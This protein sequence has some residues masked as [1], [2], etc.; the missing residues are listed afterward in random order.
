MSTSRRRFVQGA[1][2]LGLGL[3]TGCGRW[4]WQAQPP[5]RVPRI[6][7]LGLTAGATTGTTGFQQGLLELGWVDGQNLTIEWRWAEGRPERL[8][9]LAAELVHLNVDII[10]AVAT[11]AALAAKN[12]TA[13]IPIVFL[14]VGDPLYSGLVP[15]L[16]HPGGHITGLTQFGAQL[17]GKRLELLKESL[18]GIIQVAVL[19]DPSTVGNSPSF[20]ETELAAQTLG[21][22][23]HPVEAQAVEELDS[24][25]Q[26]ATAVGAEGI[27]VL[28]HPV[29]AEARGRIVGLVAVTRLPAIYDTR[30]FVD[31]GGL[32]SYG[33]NTAAI[34]RRGAAY[35]D[36]IL[37]GAKPADLPVEQPTIF[38]FTINLKAAQALGLTI[39]QHVLLQATEVIQ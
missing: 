15:S 17:S 8:P 32:M 5:T 28:P 35:V 14:N 4:P 39:P 26:A 13:T 1:G 25:F 37:K 33:P 2:A 9:A 29:Y 3:L 7:Y 38:D 12:A 21:L 19:W 11:S 23:M 6:G 34:S 20:K 22:R 18:P 30:L 24:A 27:V 36:K 31:A 10:V 16:S